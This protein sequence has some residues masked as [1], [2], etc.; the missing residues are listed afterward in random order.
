[1]K[2]KN[3]S[4]HYSRNLFFS[5]ILHAALIAS[6]FL[7]S[8]FVPKN[9]EQAIWVELGT[10]GEPGGGGGQDGDGR[11]AAAPPPA[12]GFEAPP[13]PPPPGAPE[14]AEP[15]PPKPTKTE[16]PKQETRKPDIRQPTV[17]VDVPKRT[18]KKVERPKVEAKTTQPKKSEP[19]KVVRSEKLVTRAKPGATATTV[20]V[21]GSKGKQISGKGTVGSG[22]GSFNASAFR[23]KLAGALGSGTGTGMGTGR[24]GPPGRGF[25]VGPPTGAGSGTGGLPSQF[26]WYYALIKDTLDKAWLQPS[27]LQ[28]QLS[29]VVY[30]RIQRDGTISNVWFDRKSGNVVMDD[31]VISAINTVG[32]IAPLP[33]GLGNGYVD[34]P[35]GFELKQVERRG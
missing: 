18:E 19:G 28:G 6:V 33:P 35:V 22:R 16:P 30:I 26:G 20:G 8:A 21:P 3:G 13:S 4:P 10:G 7:V 32:K 9:P 15:V 11:E 25:G 31:S 24:K 29:C 17:P 1:M 12:P 34:I 27:H 2:T 14:V 5:T 23:N